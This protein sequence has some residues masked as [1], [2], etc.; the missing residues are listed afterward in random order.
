MKKIA[1]VG[2]GPS[3]MFIIKKLL[4][5]N[6]HVQ[7][8]VFEKSD[9]L[10]AGMPY[11]KFGALDEH[12][13][14]VSPNEI[15]TIETS[16]AEWIGD[17]EQS[18]LNAFGIDAKDFNEFKVMPRLLFGKYL[19]GQFQCLLDRAKLKSIQ[20]K[21]HYNSEV[22]D[23]QKLG[24]GRINIV[25]DPKI[26]E[27]FDIVVICIGHRWPKRLEGSIPKYFDSPYPPSKLQFTANYPVAIR[28][29]SLT[30][31]D[32]IRTLAR[33][34]GSFNRLGNGKLM[35]SA[36]D[37][38]PNFK[39]VLHSKKGLLP[40]IRFHLEDPRL[41][42]KDMMK[43]DE[44]AAHIY[45]NKGFVSLDFLFEENYKRILIEKDPVVYEFIKDM[46][47]EKF[48]SYIMDSRFGEDAF[49]LFRIEY[50]A[51][52]VSIR[53]KKS[54][55]WKEL[56]GIF[57][58]AT[59]YPAKYF[60]A[61]DMLRYKELMMPLISMIIAYVPQSSAEELMALHDAGLLNIVSVTDDDKIEP[62]DNGGIIYK[63]HTDDGIVEERYNAFIDSIGQPHFD[64][65]QF[66]FKSL[67]LEGNLRQATLRFRDNSL[68]QELFNRGIVG[69][70]KEQT[71]NQYS[72]CVPGIEINDTFQAID[73][74]GV[75]N[76]EIYIMAAPYIGGYNP[77]YSGLDFCDEASTR[78]AGSILSY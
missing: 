7:I 65:E 36:S 15:P 52:E 63:R 28:G 69:I 58:F 19:E 42:P 14:N 55:Y 62:V 60:S 57:S 50:E 33:N 17:C 53:S 37:T 40:S 54:I 26:Y 18:T 47:V 70:E 45:S 29:A 68:A 22:T 39:I 71:T 43:W 4:D 32:A 48:V 31:V 75:A 24:K 59:N 11:S 8:E 76:K 67:V 20:C 10:G 35:F 41:T 21:V 6:A 46:D 3:A 5:E 72:L 64:I 1:I 73:R 27:G 38:S 16:F 9:V 44:I 49:Q 23:I 30:A 2:G 61:E 25:A 66:P 56:L 77:D 12:V 34:N 74:Y 78:I 13:T 51:A